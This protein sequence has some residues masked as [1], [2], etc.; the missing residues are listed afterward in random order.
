MKNIMKQQIGYL[1]TDQQKALRNGLRFS[2]FY[3]KCEYKQWHQSGN[4][5]KHYFYK[6][7]KIEGEYKDWYYNGNLK[8]HNFVRNNGWYE[9]KDAKKLFPEGPWI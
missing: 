5:Y 2:G 4:L 7:G 9:I 8:L 3:Y 6:D 1:F